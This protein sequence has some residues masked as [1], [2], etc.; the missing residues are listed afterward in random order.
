MTLEEYNSTVDDYAD[1]V[2]RFVLRSIRDNDTAQ[3]IVQESFMRLWERHKQVDVAK[4]RSYLFTTAYHI[5]V[6]TTKANKRL[7][8]ESMGGIPVISHHDQYSDLK[9][10]L[11]EAVDQLPEIQKNVIL[12][13]DYEGYSYNEIATICSLSESQV[14]VYI[15]RGRIALKKYIGNMETVI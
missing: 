1:R 9:E 7:S 12:L 11:N 4:A 15:Y 8:P 2:F 13:R 10:V 3:D 14:K 5:V 6:D